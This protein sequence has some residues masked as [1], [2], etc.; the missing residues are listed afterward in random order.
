MLA[1]SLSIGRVTLVVALCISHLRSRTLSG[2]LPRFVK[3]I[4]KSCHLQ[5]DKAAAAFPGWQQPH[6]VRLL[7]SALPGLCRRH[8]GDSEIRLSGAQGGFF[9]KG[10]A[11]GVRAGRRLVLGCLCFTI[12]V[13]SLAIKKKLRGYEWGLSV[14][15]SKKGLMVGFLCRVALQG[16]GGYCIFLIGQEQPSREHCDGGH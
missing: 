8:C 12:C 16:F 13:L 15:S 4:G 10:V 5:A 1:I 14:F 11:E 3:R 6:R 2:V 7:R 9:E